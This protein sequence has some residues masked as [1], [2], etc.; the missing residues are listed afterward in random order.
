MKRLHVE[1][2]ATGERVQVQGRA[3][4]TSLKVVKIK[5]LIKGLKKG[6][7]IYVLKTNKLEK[8]L[9][10]QAPEWLSEYQDVFSEDLT[11]LPLAK[12]LVHEIEIILSPNPWPRFLT[13]YQCQKL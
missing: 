8:D 2:Q 5:C 7:P 10:G 4:K 1:A 11:K 9:E 6:L 3:G 12:G 13:R